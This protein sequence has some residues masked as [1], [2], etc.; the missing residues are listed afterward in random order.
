MILFLLRTPTSYFRPFRTYFVAIY[1]FFF[2]FPLREFL[3]FFA[4]EETLLRY[5]AQFM[6]ASAISIAILWGHLTTRLYAHPRPFSLRGVLADPGRPV[7]FAFFLYLVPMAVTLAASFVVPNAILVGREREAV[8]FFSGITSNAVG[9]GPSFLAVASSVIF[10]FVCYPQIMLFYLRSQLKDREVRRALKTIALCFGAISILL[11]AFNALV[12]FGYSILGITHIAVVSLLIVVVRSFNQP[13]FLKAFFGVA[14]VLEPIP[15]LKRQGQLILI[16]R[17]QD[18]KFGPFSRY[19]SENLSQPVRVVFFHQEDE[20]IVREGLSRNGLNVRHHLLKGDLRLVPLRSLYQG[21]GMADE[22]AAIEFCRNLALE[23][24][25][26]GKEGLRIMIDY[27]D[28]TKRPSQK[29]VEH[30]SDE[31]WTS[32]DQYLSVLMAFTSNAFQGLETALTTLKSRVQVLDL[33]DSM[34]F[35]SRTIG[36]SHQEITGKKILLE[37]DPLS[38]YEKV[39]SSLLAES[40]SNIERIVVFTRRESPLHSIIGEQPGLKTFVMTSRVSYPKVEKQDK[41]LLPTYDSS[42]LLDALNKTIETYAGATFTLIFDSI[43]HYI[44]IIGPERA[45]SLV[46]QALELMIS[47]RITAVFLINIKA[48]DEKTALTFENLFDMELV[49]RQGA[50]VPEVK[51]D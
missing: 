16:Y 38:D 1:A 45:H 48:H 50:R 39:F 18:D 4:A 7:N 51:R 35:F 32:P 42:L 3:L 15:S 49:C 14:P 24:R 5:S 29:F 37:Y 44:H 40:R 34:D 20:D 31:R 2:A 25:T 26:I 8:Y 12:T 11:L 33:T 27:G 46:R 28:Q 10:S 47:N 21:E 30:L 9:Y 41:V 36:L 23:G 6:V 43:T 17:S 19:L 13:T 22:E